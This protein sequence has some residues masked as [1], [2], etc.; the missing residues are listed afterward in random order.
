[1]TEYKKA[2][3]AYKKDRVRHTG[4]Y[5]CM[6]CGRAHEKLHALFVYFGEDGEVS[7]YGCWVCDKKDFA[8]LPS[9]NH[10]DNYA[11]DKLIDKFQEEKRE[12]A[13][14]IKGFVGSLLRF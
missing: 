5:V 2:C 12:F 4:S 6:N 7:D 9:W 11:M 3:E 1:M 14:P 10:H 8:H 13:N